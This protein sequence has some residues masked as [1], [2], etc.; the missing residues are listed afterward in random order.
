MPLVRQRE[1]PAAEDVQQDLDDV[2]EMQH[3]R[4]AE[5]DLGPVLGHRA[6]LLG[7]R[8]FT[9]FGEIHDGHVGLQKSHGP[10]D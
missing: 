7:P 2:E 5:A 3:D 4:C 9:P 10:K 6:D 1:Q 8:A